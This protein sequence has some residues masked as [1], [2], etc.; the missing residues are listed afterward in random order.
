MKSVLI[1]ILKTYGTKLKLIN[2]EDTFLNKM[3][4]KYNKVVGVHLFPHMTRHTW[5]TEMQKALYGKI[6]IDVVSVIKIL[7]GHGLKQSDM[8]SH[9]TNYEPYLKDAM[10]KYHYL[11]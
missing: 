5:I 3:L 8:T 10:I 6:D 11:L 7:A 2:R 9:Y 4:Y 1:H